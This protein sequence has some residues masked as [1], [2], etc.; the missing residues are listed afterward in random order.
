MRVVQLSWG[1]ARQ[2]RNW[3]DERGEGNDKTLVMMVHP[4]AIPRASNKPPSSLTSSTPG[5]SS[6]PV[7][8]KSRLDNTVIPLHVLLGTGTVWVRLSSRLHFAS[9]RTKLEAVKVGKNVEMVGRWRC[10]GLG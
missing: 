8:K 9:L 6:P 7:S 1:R 3:K 4:P 2:T 10:F 5:V